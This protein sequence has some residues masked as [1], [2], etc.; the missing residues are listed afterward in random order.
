VVSLQHESYNG[1]LRLIRRMM[2]LTSVKLQLRDIDNTDLRYKFQRSIKESFEMVRNEKRMAA[3]DYTCEE[4]TPPW[5]TIW[6]QNKYLIDYYVEDLPAGVP[7]AHFPKG[8]DKGALTWAVEYV[9]D[10]PEHWGPVKL[11][12]V[13]GLIHVHSLELLVLAGML[14]LSNSIGKALKRAKLSRPSE[15]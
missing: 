7:R 5:T 13:L 1:K 2:E 14:R 6:G 11:S 15:K 12:Q 9:L 4:W 8:D 3:P 10:H